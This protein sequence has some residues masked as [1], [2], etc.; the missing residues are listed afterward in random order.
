[1]WHHRVVRRPLLLTPPWRRGWWALWN[2][3]GLLAA[4]V[5]IGAVIGLV[6]AAPVLFVS[7]VGAGA[8]QVQYARQCPAT[9]APNLN[10]PLGV[11]VIDQPVDDPLGA[12]TEAVG[13]DP[14]FAAPERILANYSANPVEFGAAEGHVGFLARPDALEHVQL[15]GPQVAGDLW[16]PDSLQEQLGAG[17]GD[18][19]HVTVSG[20]RELDLV[21]AGVFRDLAQEP[22]DAYWCVATRAIMPEDMYGEVF[23]PPMAVVTPERFDELDLLAGLRLTRLVAGF[24]AP[25]RTLADAERLTT[26]TAGVAERIEASGAGSITSGIDRLTQRARLVRSAVRDTTLPVAG[27]AVTCALVLAAVLGVLWLRVRRMSCTALLTVGVAPGWVGAKAAIETCAAVVGGAAGGVL[28]ARWSMRA[29]APADVV[30]PGALGW[31]F[32]AAGVAALAGVALIGLTVAWS[33]RSLLRVAAPARRSWWRFV[34]F[35]AGLAL[36]AWWAARDV[37]PSAL[38]PVEGRRVVDTSAAVLL[39]PLA[40]LACGAAVA[41]RVWWWFTR[42]WRGAGLPTHLTSRLAA[43]RLQHGARA[44]SAILGAGTLALGVSVFGLAMNAS[45]ARTG[46]AKAAVFVGSDVALLVSGELPA[47]TPGATEVWRRESMTYE[48]LEVDVL[49]IDTETFASVAFWDDAF[50]DVPLAELM[51]RLAGASRGG[52]EEPAWPA[53]L[54]GTAPQEGLLSNPNTD[55]DPVQVRVVGAASAFP[56]APRER[57]TLVTTLGAVADGP[58]GFRHFVWARGG[59]EEWRA[60][61]FNLGAEPLLGISRHDAVDSSVL[62]FAAWSFD[63]VRALGVFVGLLVVVA[64]LLYLSARQRQQALGFAFLRRMGFTHRRHWWALVL[65]VGGL[66]L[67]VLGLGTGLALFSARLVSPNVDPLPLL[68]PQPLTVVPWLGM[69]GAAVLGAVVALLGSAAAQGLGSRV[70]VAEVLRDGT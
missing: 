12:L 42:R 67:M 54:V 39:L 32:L 58:I 43:R 14:S 18:T 52:T 33:A 63:F 36:A 51:D 35:E 55:R 50:A 47:G 41:S 16:L 45:L 31:A 1:M 59:Y 28:S 46:E 61:L 27:L 65:E 13:D 26:A 53:L 25:P 7:S 24:A 3:P 17:P 21:V 68:A 70:D 20:G 62:R 56:G 48:G 49:A 8:V 57:P 23:P 60:E 2:R 5:L 69:A 38:V 11:N 44:G 34:P 4:T 19:I 9:L 40:V 22:L 6:A 29:W 10:I 66:M 64:L 37:R 15:V 30:E